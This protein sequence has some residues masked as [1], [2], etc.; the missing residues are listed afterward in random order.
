MTCG[1]PH[2]SNFYWII[3]RLELY[4]LVMLHVRETP[5]VRE[6]LLPLQSCTPENKKKSDTRKVAKPQGIDHVGRGAR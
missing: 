1:S 4:F 5:S 6:K 3:I 2:W